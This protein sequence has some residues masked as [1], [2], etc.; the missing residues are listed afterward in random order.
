[1]RGRSK[2][3]PRFARA[4]GEE[5]DQGGAR[6]DGA[7]IGA[8]RGASLT[9]IAWATAVG[10][11]LRLWLVV[12]G[13]PP[14]STLTGEAI[15]PVLRAYGWLAPQARPDWPELWRNGL[16][17]AC[18]LSLRLWKDHSV[19]LLTPVQAI[20]SLAT[21]PLAALA[22]GRRLGL[23]AG[24]WAAWALALDPVAVWQASRFLP[25]CY[26]AFFLILALAL[27][28]SGRLRWLPGA[29]ASLALALWFDAWG[30]GGLRALRPLELL[31]PIAAGA[32]VGLRFGPRIEARLLEAL[33]RGALRRLLVA[34]AA[35][36]VGALFMTAPLWLGSWYENHDWDRYLARLVEYLRGWR[37]GQLFPRWCPDCYG[38][39]GSPLFDFHPP[40]IFAPSALFALLGASL[41]TALKL[42][43]VL[44]AG[45]GAVG[46]FLLVRG[47]TRRSDAALVG[48]FAFTFAPYQLMNLYLR[49]DLSEV[50]ALSL[51]PMALFCYR[52]CLR[53]PLA[54]VPILG[55]WGALC[56]AGIVL[57]HTIT[58]Q[59][60]TE[61]LALFLV[62][63]AARALRRGEWRRVGAGAVAFTAALGLSAVYVVP[64]FVE[65]GL[66]HLDRITGGYFTA[67]R[68]LVPAWRFFRFWFYDFVVDGLL[69]D[70]VRMPFSV[71]L[72][73]IA[74][75]LAAVAGLFS[76]RARAAL[77]GALPWWAGLAALLVLVTPQSAP[78]WRLLPL[79][80]FIEFPWRL[81]GPASL[82][83]AVALGATWAAW[84]PAS[85]PRR[86]TFA[87]AGA[88][89][90]VAAALP[91][92][93][94]S[95]YLGD[96][97]LRLTPADVQRPVDQ[98]MTSVDEHLPLAVSR[99][100]DGPRRRLWTQVR[101]Q[102][103]AT[104]AQRGG[105][106]YD[107][108]LVVKRAPAAIDL[109]V[110]W[111]V[112]WRADTYAGPAPAKLLP[113][114]SGLARLELS[115]PG[116]YGVRVR[117]D[118]TPARTAGSAVS[119]VCLL[120]LYPALRLLSR[121]ERRA[122]TPAVE[123]GPALA[124]TP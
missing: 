1:M 86:G 123:E 51:F 72:P 50:V 96:A 80:S 93:R 28:S 61:I 99:N 119:L 2:E 118:G 106:D 34:G 69:G 104:V 67:T 81:L 115:A 33:P 88:L 76:P 10:A 11:L 114:S 74:A 91:M 12:W 4:E 92:E 78:L 27:A 23:R 53:A 121:E 90:I 19:E 97:A 18:T 120:L 83:G 101:G 16:V 46:T 56:H 122:A 22:V 48:A 30:A 47:E 20:L 65:K 108:R 45:L 25:D 89:L 63:G 82:L 58:G 13:H 66:T 102:L 109:S 111:F 59:W 64:A 98:G 87:A 35:L 103:D 71:G 44:S 55:S 3:T 24:G 113:S 15:A 70:K 54:R 79:G 68:H 40:G 14:A 112:G 116:S 43:L 26:V 49:G 52:E 84:L 39:Y 77:R 60:T 17:A 117:F 105:T 37:D 73:L 94:V 100:P 32:L 75:M 85:S 110:H 62:P 7:S 31:V 6:G 95:G 107:V 9:P 29:A 21:V 38:G 42:T 36:L 41:P 124:A 8:R 57:S 5:R